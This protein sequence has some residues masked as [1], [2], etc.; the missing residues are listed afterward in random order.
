MLPGGQASA[1]NWTRVQMVLMWELSRKAAWGRVTWARAMLASPG[2]AWRLATSRGFE[3]RRLAPSREMLRS[4][5][6]GSLAQSVAAKGE[7]GWAR[8]PWVEVRVASV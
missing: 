5:L 6:K 1:A 2:L 8:A 4:G 3:V 7:V